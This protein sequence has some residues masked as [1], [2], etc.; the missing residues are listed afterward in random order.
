[1]QHW[2][3]EWASEIVGDCSTQRKSYKR[4]MQLKCHIMYVCT[5]FGQFKDSLFSDGQC[6]YLIIAEITL[7]GATSCL[8]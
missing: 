2:V 6:Y 3:N 5:W 1:M 8:G 4:K 7:L